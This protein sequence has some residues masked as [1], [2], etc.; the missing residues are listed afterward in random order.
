M[1]NR[2]KRCRDWL[3]KERLRQVQLHLSLRNKLLLREKALLLSVEK[4][5]PTHLVPPLLLQ[6]PPLALSE[7]ESD[8][9]LLSCEVGPLGVGVGGDVCEDPQSGQVSA[10]CCEVGDV[11]VC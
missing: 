4:A 6:L 7:E 2:D 10:D 1:L 8:G 5:L 11:L 9:F 3:Q